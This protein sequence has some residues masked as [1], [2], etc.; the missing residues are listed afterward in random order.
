METWA[1]SYASAIGI[2]ESIILEQAK[3]EEKQRHVQVLPTSDEA[4]ASQ[5]EVA[6]T[7]AEAGVLPAKV[8]VK[9]LWDNTFNDAIAKCSI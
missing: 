4:I 9:P 5:Q 2:D 1:K 6:D 8:S 7:F 3:Q